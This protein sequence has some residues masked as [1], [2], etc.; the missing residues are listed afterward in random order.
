MTPLARHSRLL[1][2]A[3]ILGAGLVCVA[4]AAL[5]AGNASDEIATAHA[6]AILAQKAGT[7]A[8]S[9]THLHHVINCLVGPAGKGFDAKA[10]N[11]CKGQGGGA[12]P[13]STANSALH[14]QLESA[15]AEAEGGL[16]TD[17][18]DG[19]HQ[20]AAKLAATLATAS[21]PKS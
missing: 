3:L 6:H 19:A 17:S 13:D 5:A 4:T 11:P 18:L 14:G 21:T 9:H 2:G 7:L 1:G 15:L 8:M 20:A 10:G 16:K 12:I